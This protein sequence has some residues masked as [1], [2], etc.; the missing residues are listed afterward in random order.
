MRGAEGVLWM[1]VSCLKDRAFEIV[2][3]DRKQSAETIANIK[4]N[5]R[6]FRPY[7][8]GDAIRYFAVDGCEPMRAHYDDAGLDLRADGDYLVQRGEVVTVGLGVRFEIP[9]GLFG[10]LA[11]RSSV[12][13][14]KVFM[15]GGFGVIDSGYRGELAVPVTVVDDPVTIPKGM[16]VAQLIFIPCL[17]PELMRVMSPDELSTSDRG[18]GGFGSTGA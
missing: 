10:Q 7:V 5:G 11:L 2:K 12:G 17:T 6:V 18:V 8:L 9:R 14:M 1:G 16:R 15:P 3:G 4:P 13:R